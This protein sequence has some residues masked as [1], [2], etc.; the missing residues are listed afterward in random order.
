ML[1]RNYLCVINICDINEMHTYS[2][3]YHCMLNT[4]YTDT[5]YLGKVIT[6]VTPALKHIKVTSMRYT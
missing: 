3:L 1:L 6:Y 4:L 5:I 2:V